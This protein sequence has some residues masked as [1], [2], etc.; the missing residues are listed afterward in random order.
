M[1]HSS[2]DCNILQEMLYI[3][4]KVCHTLIFSVRRSQ[5]IAFSQINPYHGLR[6]IHFHAHKSLTL[7]K[8]SFR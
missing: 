7:I 6:A 8:D 5:M 1:A 3:Y 4:W 2:L